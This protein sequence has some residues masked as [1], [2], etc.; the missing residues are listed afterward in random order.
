MSW[1]YGQLRAG[2][3]QFGHQLLL[4]LTG[5]TSSY[6]CDAYFHEA[7]LFSYLFFLMIF[8]ICFLCPLHV[9]ALYL[10]TVRIF[11]LYRGFFFIFYFSYLLERG[12]FG[13]PCNVLASI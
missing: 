9:S 12:L 3:L 2:K 11:S 6:A 10:P 4:D 13:L 1:I 8:L 5:Q 7:I